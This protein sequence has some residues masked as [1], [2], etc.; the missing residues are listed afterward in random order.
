[1]PGS[2]KKKLSVQRFDSIDYKK[3]DEDS[4]SAES[5]VLSM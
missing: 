5:L 4:M 3:E 2:I 1:M